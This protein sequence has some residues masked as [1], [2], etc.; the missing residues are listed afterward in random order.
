MVRLVPASPT[1]GG[2]TA[3]PAR[4]AS[5]G[6]GPAGLRT[7]ARLSLADQ[8][9]QLIMV[10]HATGA[11]VGPA[12]RDSL[13]RS[14][15]GSVVLLET[16][17]AGVRGVRRLTDD[18][19]ATAPGPRGIAPLVAVDQEGGQ[20]Q[21]L[22]G[23]GFAAIP[24]ADEQATLGAAELTRRSTGWGRQLRRAGVDAD[25]APVADVVPAGRRH[26]NRPVGRLRR[27]YG[28]DHRDVAGA[29]SAFVAGMDAAGVATAVK[30]FPG[31]GRVRGNTDVDR[32]VTDTVTTADDPGFAGFAAVAGRVDMVMVSTVTY[33][34]IDPDHRAVFSPAVLRLIRADLGFTGVVVSDDLGAAAAVADVP[35]GQRA[36]RF[37]A[38]GGDLVVDADPASAP[39]MAR[40]IRDRAGRDERFADRV[41]RSAARVL[42]LKQRRG[43]TR[44][45]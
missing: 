2:S 27:G 18:L 32:N 3:G 5:P 38:A 16:S 45:G 39:A 1:A 17:T 24:A 21:R 19:R 10:G 30:H 13:R 36:T 29:V 44:C 41:E 25:L 40:A 34:R 14:R 31:L 43:L 35:P 9:G 22:Q 11:P 42:E 33:T 4:T 26:D 7:A 20:V 12:T 37:V 15:A 8:A 28:S 23:P 6:P